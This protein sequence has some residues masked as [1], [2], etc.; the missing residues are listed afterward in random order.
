MMILYYCTHD[1]SFLSF[2]TCSIVLSPHRS[3]V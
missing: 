1:T 3:Q 2:R